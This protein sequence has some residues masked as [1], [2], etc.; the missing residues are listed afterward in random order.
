VKRENKRERK[1]DGDN[2]NDDDYEKK[3]SHGGA[4]AQRI[5]KR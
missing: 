1:A 5:G 2:D 4:E 3:A